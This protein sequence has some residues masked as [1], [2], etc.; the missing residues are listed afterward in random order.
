LSTMVTSINDNGAIVG[1]FGNAGSG[2]E[3]GFILQNG[4]YKTVDNPKGV[5]G[6]TFLN[7]INTSGT[8]VGVYF[9]NEN[10]QGFIY[11]NGT[12]KD[13]KAPGSSSTTTSGINALGY[14]TGEAT[15]SGSTGYTAHCQ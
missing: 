5:G 3:H 13:I 9:P 14:V 4:V 15:I 11:I 8:I 1:S 6:G 7:D 12:F 2:K 10:P